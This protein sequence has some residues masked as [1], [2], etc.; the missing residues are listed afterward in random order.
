MRKQ[1]FV[2]IALRRFGFRLN[3]TGSRRTRKVVPIFGLRYT[4]V[5][6]L[7]LGVALFGL[8]ITVYRPTFTSVYFRTTKSNFTRTN[9]VNSYLGYFNLSAKPRLT[10]LSWNTHASPVYDIMNTLAPFGVK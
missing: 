6:I 9:D 4:W 8:T 5:G 1:S 3:L 10:V 7:L 2:V